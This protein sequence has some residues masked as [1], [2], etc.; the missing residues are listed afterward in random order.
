MRTGK[1]LGNVSFPQLDAFIDQGISTMDPK[2]RQKIYSDAVKV[3][4]EEVL[5]AWTYQQIDIYGVNERLN[6]KA[7]TDEL[8]VVFDMTFKK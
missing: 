5:W 8:M 4:K 1:L 3:V 7:R 6:W 2:K